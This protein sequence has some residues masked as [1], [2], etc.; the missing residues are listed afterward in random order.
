MSEEMDRSTIRMFAGAVIALAG[1]AI[2]LTLGTY[3]DVSAKAKWW[4]LMTAVGTVGAVIV[5]LWIASSQRRDKHRNDVML[6]RLLAPRIAIKISSVRSELRTF[7]ALWAETPD[8]FLNEPV[9]AQ[10]ASWADSA[11]SEFLMSD[12]QILSAS[13]TKCAEHLAGALSYL[14]MFSGLLGRIH[15]DPGKHRLMLAAAL[16]NA[17]LAIETLELARVDCMTWKKWR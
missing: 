14:D 5:A 6:A 16:P 11:R 2:G 10:A 3:I 4:E 9:R 13:P 8:C 7:Y 17:M 15:P 12:L 1:V